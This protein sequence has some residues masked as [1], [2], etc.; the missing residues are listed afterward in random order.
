[1]RVPTLQEPRHHRQYSRHRTMPSKRHHIRPYL[2]WGCDT[3]LN[4]LAIC[5]GCR[6]GCKNGCN[7]FPYLLAGM[8]HLQFPYPEV[9]QNIPYWIRNVRPVHVIRAAQCSNIIEIIQ[10][11]I[12]RRNGLLGSGSVVV[13][14]R[15]CRCTSPAGSPSPE[16]MAVL[17]IS[18]INQA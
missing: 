4:D 3:D 16:D 1:M 10:H 13:L 2:P 18:R 11:V 7:R 15:Q 6:N 9:I 8:C 14:H 5:S 12:S 17:L